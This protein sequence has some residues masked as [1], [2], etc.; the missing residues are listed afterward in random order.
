MSAELTQVAAPGAPARNWKPYPAYKDSGVEWPGKVP[1]H[2]NLK[3]LKSICYM[4]GRIGWQGLKQSEFTTEGPYLIT[5]MNFKD[6]VIRWEEVYH[7]T[8]ERYNEA[9]EIQLKVDDVLMTKDGTIGKLLYVDVLPDKASLNS[10]LLVLRPLK[11]SFLPKY[12]Y[13]LLQSDVFKVHIELYKTGT[14]FFGI[15][16]E[17]V[18]IFKTILPPKNEQR[19]IARYLDDRTRKIDSLIEKKQKLIE[20]LKEERAAVINQAVTKGLDPGAPMRDSGVEWLGKIPKNWNIEKL[21]YLVK[22][23]LEYGANESAELEDTNLPRYIRITDFGDDG[24]LRDDTFKSLPFEIAKNYLL[25]ERDILFARSGATVGKTFQFKNYQGLACFAGYLIKAPPDENKIMSDFLYLFTKSN[26]YENWKN[27]N[28]IQ[29][30]I[31]NISAD[32]Y[33]LLQITVPPIKEQKSI[34][35]FIE[36]K[37][38]KTDRTIAKI[39]KEIALL[40][41]YRTALISEVVTGKIDVRGE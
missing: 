20:L 25:Q 1:E 10:H 32:K 7:I 11:E 41:E 4:K 39:E 5:G 13:Y 3:K 12:L 31:Q 36:S 14:T 2:W 40:Q 33:N 24:E 9:P 16:Q 37:L 21:K 18:G 17:A 35:Q 26:T 28:F 6:G 23:K 34:V 22:G 30:T 38:A 8:E 15:T 29:A 27:S 19:F